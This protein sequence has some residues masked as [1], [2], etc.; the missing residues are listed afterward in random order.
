M[1][2]KIVLGG[3]AQLEDERKSHVLGGK[4]IHFVRATVVGNNCKVLQP[5]VCLSTKVSLNDLPFIRRARRNAQH[6]SSNKA[7]VE[8]VHEVPP[9]SHPEPHMNHPFCKIDVNQRKR[10]SDVA[11]A[12]S[13]TPLNNKTLD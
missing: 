7:A 11:A 10:T 4:L 9:T 1:S 3:S 5:A 13:G 2:Q 6:K 12:E 8:R